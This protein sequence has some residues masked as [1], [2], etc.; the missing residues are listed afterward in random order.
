MMHDWLQKY[1]LLH[2]VIFGLYLDSMPNF[3]LAVLFTLLYSQNLVLFIIHLELL[4]FSLLIQEKVY[5]VLIRLMK[6]KQAF[7]FI[8]KPLFIQKYALFFAFPILSL[9]SQLRLDPL[10]LILCVEPIFLASF[11]F[12]VQFINILKNIDNFRCRYRIM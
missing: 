1:H 6:L 3:I 7:L 2:V 9:L 11:L 12:F 4:S 10:K 8:L 5:H